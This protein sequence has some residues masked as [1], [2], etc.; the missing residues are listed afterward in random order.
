[1][2]FLKGLVSPGVLP[3]V[4]A[5][6]APVN[7]PIA[8]TAPKTGGMGGNDAFFRPLLGSIMTGN[9]HEMLTK[10]LKLKPPLFLGSENEDA[11]DFILDC[12]ERLYKLGIVHQH[13][14][15]FVSFQ[16]QDSAQ[17]QSRAVVPTGNGNNGRGHPQGE[18]GSNQ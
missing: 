14:A 2:S 3:A 12:Y 6:Q 7:P 15:E 18:R 11:Y 1:M 16:L 5:T 13:G 17:Q 4:Q 10:F 9:E 8:S